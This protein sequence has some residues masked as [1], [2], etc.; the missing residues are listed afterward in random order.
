MYKAIFV[1][2]KLL[3]GSQLIC[4]PDQENC[5]AIHIIFRF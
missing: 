1:D 5:T 4:Q 3:L 2:V